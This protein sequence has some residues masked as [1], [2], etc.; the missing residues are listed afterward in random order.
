MLNLS[1]ISTFFN[2]WNLLQTRSWD[3]LYLSTVCHKGPSRHQGKYGEVTDEAVSLFL[4]QACKFR[5]V[6]TQPTIPQDLVLNQGSWGDQPDPLT[7]ADS[8]IVALP[9]FNK[10]S[11]F[12][13]FSLEVKFLII[14]SS[15]SLGL[16]P[17]RVQ[18]KSWQ[19]QQSWLSPIHQYFSKYDLELLGLTYRPKNI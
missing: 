18:G 17:E 19:C 9:C 7:T 1:K 11:K 14:V 2:Y 4:V 6:K 8:N 3:Y 15:Q 10:L 12:P 5:D 16:S 13:V